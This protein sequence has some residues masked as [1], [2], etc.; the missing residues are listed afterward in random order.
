[1]SPHGG[2]DAEFL[3]ISIRNTGKRVMIPARPTQAWLDANTSLLEVNIWETDTDAYAYLSPINFVFTV[4]EFFKRE[5]KPIYK[6]LTPSI[7]R[8]NGGRDVLG[9]EEIPDFSYLLSLQIL[10]EGSIRE[11]NSRLREKG[12]DEITIE[13]FRPNIIVQGL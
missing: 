7:L 3:V 5:V 12:H 11:L 2:Q 1:L 6:A 8:G 9:R 13:R 10:N 4:T